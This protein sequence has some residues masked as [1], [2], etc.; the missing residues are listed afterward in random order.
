MPPPDADR[1]GG[2]PAYAQ[3]LWLDDITWSGPQLQVA[4]RVDRLSFSTAL[5][6]DSV[7][8][9]ALAEVHGRRAIDAVAFHIALFEL[10]KG[11]SF[12]PGRLC[13]ADRWAPFLTRELLELWRTVARGV[14]AQWR[15]EHH[16][17]DY[18]GPEL[19]TS[20]PPGA[21]GLDLRLPA[22]PTEHLWFC[23]GGKDSLLASHL[24]EVLEEP[25]DALSYAHSTYGRVGPQIELID[26]VV[27]ER[28][29]DARHRIYIY[30]SATDLPVDQLGPYGG[31][32]YVLAA[33]TPASVFATLPVALTHGHRNLVLAH[34]R[35]ADRGDLLWGPTGEDVNHQW[36]KSLDAEQLLDDYVRAHLVPELRIFSVLQP[37]HDA[38]V[39]GSLHAVE[40]VL[41]AA[42]SCNV[43][44]PWCLRCPKCAYVWI[45]YKAWLPW[46]LVDPVFAHA[47]LL[48]VGENQVWFRQMLGLGEHRPFEC[49]GQVDE[50]RLAFALAR[51]R[52]LDGAAMGLL[53]EC[54]DFDPA[55][56]LDR[57]LTVD[58]TG[59]RIPEPLGAGIVGFFEDQARVVRAEAAALLGL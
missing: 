45:G 28:R 3:T 30:D 25:Y 52:G 23:G 42:H 19:T 39:F 57:F 54:H 1:P 6:Y 32:R 34:E 43:D 40:K 18:E 59:H 10:N 37:V 44:K 7:D 38:L 58:R 15:Y 22:G 20:A 5:W 31:V 35:S 4:W 9:D 12:G 24:L 53:D 51:A 50:T 8:F 16:R 29:C 41:P 56:A 13:L 55:A 27:D 36:G 2:K 17:P 48:E 21:V 47:N 46:D 14:W 49:I 26:R 33:E 11:V